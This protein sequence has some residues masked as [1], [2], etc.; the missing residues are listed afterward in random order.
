MLTINDVDVH[1]T[2]M[3]KEGYLSFLSSAVMKS[4]INEPDIINGSIGKLSEKEGNK[5]VIKPFANKNECL[6]AYNQAVKV[7]VERGWVIGWKGKPC[8]G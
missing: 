6:T 5:L 3:Y 7:S 1:F 2:F 8:Y 4:P